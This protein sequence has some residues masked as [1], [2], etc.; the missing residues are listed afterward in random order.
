M[1]ALKLIASSTLLVTAAGPV[2]AYCDS[3][4]TVEQEFRSSALV[5]V[6]KVSSARE[7]IVQSQSITGGTFY[8]VEVAEALKGNPPQK[9]QLY[10][11]NSSGRFPMEVA[12][13]YVI[14]ADRGV[15]EGIRGQQF[16]ISNCSNSAPLPKGEKTLETVRRL[17][18]LT[19]RSSQPL[20]VVMT[21]FD[22][23]KQFSV[24]RKLALASGGSAP[25]R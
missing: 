4:P 8:S 2:A 10:S 1:R 5:F 6:G 9:L 17:K 13:R 11:E 12:V 20:A 24:L 3:F 7:V 14:F 18:G 25:S 19:N 23:M 16:A 22:F 21:R 15:F